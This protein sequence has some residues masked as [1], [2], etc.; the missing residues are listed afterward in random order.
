MIN[1]RLFFIPEGSV[2][3]FVTRKAHSEEVAEKLKSRDL[4]V[5]LIHGDMHQS[6][7]NLV[8]Q[9]FKRQDAHILVATDVACKYLLWLMI[10]AKKYLKILFRKYLDFVQLIKVIFFNHKKMLGNVW[11]NLELISSRLLT[12]FSNNRYKLFSK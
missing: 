1:F 11:S 9:A 2:L 6:E 3:I 7:R 4:N 8:I 12:K 10:Y 5:L